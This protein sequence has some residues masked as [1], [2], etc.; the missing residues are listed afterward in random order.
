MKDVILQHLSMLG[1]FIVH[2]LAGL[3]ML[4]GFGLVKGI[5]A[6]GTLLH[7][8]VDGSPT[9]F[10]KIGNIQTYSGPGGQGSMLD[11]SNL[12][13]VMKEKLPGLP[14]EGT[15]TFG[16]NLD[17]SDPV[18]QAVRNARRDRTLCEFRITFPNAAATKAYFFGYVTGFTVAGGVDQVVKS[19]VTVEIDGQ[20]NWQ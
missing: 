1:D 14:D 16:I 9:A 19:N 17:P 20:V 2:A 15:F 12:D 6:Q 18:H 10:Q 4:G 5:Q 11:A 3:S 8:N 13:S 7:I